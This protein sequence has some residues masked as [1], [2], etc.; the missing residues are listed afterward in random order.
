MVRGFP[1]GLLL[2]LLAGC[3]ELPFEGNTDVVELDAC[4]AAWHL[5]SGAVQS[6]LSGEGTFR[7]TDGRFSMR[8][9]LGISATD[10][11]LSITLAASADLAG[12]DIVAA[13]DDRDFPIRATLGP[14]S[15]DDGYALVYRDGDAFFSEAAPAGWLHLSGIDGD[16]L[17]GCFALEVRSLDR[18]EELTW[19]RGLL[20]VPPL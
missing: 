17:V 16:D 9:G 7:A 15:G 11:D 2:A 3:Q 8:D 13:L 18:G 6:T 10:G 14:R 19:R 5:P 20:H 12:A 1:L 4:I